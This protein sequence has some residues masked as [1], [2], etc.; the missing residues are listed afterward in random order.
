MQIEGDT[1]NATVFSATDIQSAVLFNNL[2][3]GYTSE[4]LSH[5]PTF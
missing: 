4:S 5:A 2:T 3:F 1:E